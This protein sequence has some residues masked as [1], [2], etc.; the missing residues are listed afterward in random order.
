MATVSFLLLLVPIFAGALGPLYGEHLSGFNVIGMSVSMVGIALFA[1]PSP[2]FDS[3]WVGIV[4]ALLGG[5]ALALV[6]HQSRTLAAR[7]DEPWAA[8]AS[9]T[10][11]PG[12]LGLVLVLGMGSPPAGAALGWLLVSG[13]GYAGNTVLRLVG[14]R[15]L[16]ASSAALIAPA[17]ALTSTALAFLVLHQVPDLTTCVG[18]VV[19]VI[20]LVVA[21]RKPGA[22]SK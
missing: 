21:Q 17:S 11:V 7:G 3:E 16:S 6:W 12:I 13:L 1:Q 22:A 19:I 20:G 5:L 4:L 8:T 9:Q 18:A 10:V 14:L 2:D 15:G